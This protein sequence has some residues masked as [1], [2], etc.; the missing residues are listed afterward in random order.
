MG[1][2]VFGVGRGFGIDCVSFGATRLRWGNATLGRVG[3]SGEKVNGDSDG[4]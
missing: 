1:F 3:K 2:W 4:G